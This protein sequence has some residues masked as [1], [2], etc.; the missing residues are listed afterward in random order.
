MALSSTHRS[1]FTLCTSWLAR[2][3]AIAGR[4][5]DAAELFRSICK[6]AG[7][8]GLMPEEFDPES[9]RGLGNY[10]QAYSHLGLIESAFE[11]AKHKSP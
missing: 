7:P 3:L 5:D 1:R 2:S 6:C 11:L 9:G 10:P 4:I 8:T